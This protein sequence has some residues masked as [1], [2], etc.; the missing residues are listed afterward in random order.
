VPTSHLKGGELA[1]FD[2][3]HIVERKMKVTPR[4]PLHSPYAPHPSYVEMRYFRFAQDSELAAILFAFLEEASL[5]QN[6]NLRQSLESLKSNTSSLS[7]RVLAFAED[8]KMQEKWVLAAW[9]EG[10]YEIVVAAFVEMMKCREMHRYAVINELIQVFHVEI[11]RYR[12]EGS[13]ISG[14]IPICLASDENGTALFY[15]TRARSSFLT[16]PS[17]GHVHLKAEMFARARQLMQAPMTEAQFRNTGG[18]TCS[19]KCGNDISAFVFEQG[20]LAASFI[21]PV[22]GARIMDYMRS[23][24]NSFE[25]YQREVYAHCIGRCSQ[26]GLPCEHN[27]CKSDCQVCLRCAAIASFTRLQMRCLRCGKLVKRN[28][29]EEIIHAAKKMSLKETLRCEKCHRRYPIE[30]FTTD[31]VDLICIACA[32]APF[33]VQESRHGRSPEMEVSCSSSTAA[34]QI[35][36]ARCNV[37]KPKNDFYAAERMCHNRDCLVC[38]SCYDSVL[39]IPLAGDTCHQCGKSYPTSDIVFL[40]DKRKRLIKR[41]KEDSS[42]SGPQACRICRAPYECPKWSIQSETG[43][44]CCVCDVCYLLFKREVNA[45]VCPVCCIPFDKSQEPLLSYVEARLSQDPAAN[46][47]RTCRCCKAK[48]HT[49]VAWKKIEKLQHKCQVCDICLYQSPLMHLNCPVC[50]NQYPDADKHFL[51][52]IHNRVRQPL[53]S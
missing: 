32:Q 16:M 35:L 18:L 6:H 41:R 2:G 51:N 44:D 33:S 11:V 23:T 5:P 49:M 30:G 13:G 38:D 37:P 45:M 40:N 24:W 42:R 27:F 26:C 28:Y 15:D 12:D 1:Y 17:C 39:S 22:D 3:F 52:A 36:C 31:P 21:S 20:K 7:K 19:R 25:M 10:Y 43:H 14:N 29:F 53:Q 46:S 47:E 48:K 8:W 9:N 50:T 4:L 34:A